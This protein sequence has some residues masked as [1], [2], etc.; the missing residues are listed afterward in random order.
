MLGYLKNG[1][2]LRIDLLKRTADVKLSPEEVQKRKAEMGPYKS[3]V[4]QTPWQEIFRSMVGE[5]SEGMVFDAATKYQKLA[6]VY[7]QGRRN[8]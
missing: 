4:S 2:V 6:Q 8:H 3:P 1:D 5:L 7:G